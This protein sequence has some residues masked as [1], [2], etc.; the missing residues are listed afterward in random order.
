MGVI[1][2][3]DVFTHKYITAQ[4]KDAGGRLHIRHIKHEIGD[5]WITDIDN[6]TYVFKID[7]KRIMTYKETAARSCRVLMY[8]T[9]HYMPL[10]PEDNKNIEETLK[11]NNLPRMNLMMFGSFKLLS[12]REKTNETGKLDKEHDIK[13]LFDTIASKS[14]KFQAQA[15][16]LQ[17]YFENMA[18]QKIVTPVKEITEFIEDD[19]LATDPKYLGDIYNAIQR[20]DFKHKKITNHPVDAKKPWLII[21]ALCCII[22]VIGFMGYYLI[23]NG[24]LSGILPQFPTQLNPALTNNPSAPPPPGT[25]LTDAQVFAKYPSPDAL[26]EAIDKG[27]LQMNQLSPK[28][29]DM[30]KSYKPPQPVPIPVPGAH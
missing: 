21:I 10:S 30:I 25:K 18:V 28:V 19:L 14:Q 20:T 3:K 11:T 4:I 29:Q 7:H 12:Q 22:G 1:S 17:T 5:H 23:S 8:S 27:D 6:Q 15:Q 16:N 9:K 2:H 26:K 13:E 24:G